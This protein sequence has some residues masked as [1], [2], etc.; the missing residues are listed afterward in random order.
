MNDEEFKLRM[1]VDV[2]T[3]IADM[4]SVYA[5]ILGIRVSYDDHEKRLRTLESGACGSGNEKPDI[6]RY[7]VMGGVGGGS[8]AGILYIIIEVLRKIWG[9]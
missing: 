1:T 2:A 4:K 3:L 6:K 8:G 7:I 9:V 5:A